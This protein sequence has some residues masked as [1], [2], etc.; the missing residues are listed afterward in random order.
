MYRIT[1]RRAQR[2]RRSR[3]WL[4]FTLFFL[5]VAVG[6]IILFVLSLRPKTVVTQSKPVTTKLSYVGKTKHYVEDNFSIDIPVEWEM[7]PRPPYTYQSFTWHTV[8]KA[9]N[10]S[11]VI[12]EDT[13]PANMAVNRALIIS[14][15]SDHVEISGAASDNCVKFTKD[16][17]A[18]NGNLGVPAKWL[19]VDFLCNRN[20][21]SRDVIGTS[22]VDGVNT[23]NLKTNSG[24]KHSFF[25]TYTTNQIN[26]DY[27]VFYNAITSFGMN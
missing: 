10:Q 11:I 5:L 8:T 4:F 27:T 20:T 16:Q 15:A 2:R 13:I 9:D 24:A 7:L 14:G 12:Y 19:S 21:I 23:V 25:F 22:S 26:P 1:N 17:G 3:F 6:V 18:T